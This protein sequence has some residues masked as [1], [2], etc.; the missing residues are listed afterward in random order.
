MPSK[1]KTPPPATIITTHI[2]AD[3]DAIASM[4]AAQ[5]L[6]P[7]AQVVFPGSAEKNIRNFFINSMVYLFN[8]ADIDEI[9]L[10]GVKRLVL[11]DTRRGQ[12]IGK[13]SGL[14]ENED[15]EI[16]IFDHHPPGEEDIRPDYEVY[17]PTGATVTILAN[18][19]KEKQIPISP[20]EATVMCLGIYEDTGSFTFS[21]TT[22][23]DFLA[24]AFLL[25]KGAN[26]NI[27]ADLTAREF[28]P[29]QVGLLSDLIKSA[30]HYK[31]NGIEVVVSAI[32]TE[33]YVPDFA[34]LV[35]KMQKMESL[36]ALFAVV[37]MGGKIHIV[38]RSRI[39]EVNVADILAPLE[40]GGHPFAAAATIRDKTL[41]Q[42]EALLFESLYHR[43]RPARHAS[44]LMSSPAITTQPDVSCKA[45]SRLMTRYNVNAL[46]VTEK[47]DGAEDIQGYISRQ[48]IEKA[49]YHKLGHVPVREYMSTELAVVDPTAEL[50]EIQEK[51]IER[52]QR[53]LPVVDQGVLKG[54]ITR[55]DLLTILVNQSQDNGNR[56]SDPLQQHLT[57]KTRNIRKLMR[58]RL[59]NR[60][61]DILIS[62]GRVAHDLGY[63][64]Y[65]IGGIVR[66]L[67]L[68]RQ[69]EDVDIVV[70]GDGIAL[71]KKYAKMAGARVH[72]YEKFGT[73]VIIYPDGFKIDVASARMEYYK[74]P[75]ALPT[76][77][78]SSL[79]LD[80]FRRDFTVNTLAVQLSPDSFGILLDFFSAQ[81]DIKEKTI[82][83]LH[84]LSFVE[85]PTRVFRAIRFEQ[86]FQFTIGK[87]TTG[88]IENAVKMDFF[89]RLSGRRVFSELRQILEE[90]SPAPAIN[91]LADFNLLAVIHPSITVSK[92]LIALISAVE[93]VLAWHDLLF[94]EESYNR[95]T[96]YFLALIKGCTLEISVDICRRLELAPRHLKF[97]SQERL[98]MENCILKLEHKLPATNSKIYNRLK[99]FKIEQILFMMAATRQEAVERALSH[100]VTQLRNT[101][102]LIGGKD[103]IEMGVPR[104]P[105]FREILDGVLEGKLDGK[106]QDRQDEFEFVRKR[107]KKT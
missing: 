107:L 16:H 27:I 41:A 60:I 101:Q 94:L 6:Y 75:A 21:S 36:N 38:A 47:K 2:N 64:A 46:L 59:P 22:E 99:E 32:S 96:V 70:E 86:R 89:K 40:G 68:Y 25:S 104:G 42:V 56:V 85:D 69:N 83:I 67:F 88:L 78:M 74:F 33:D 12:R 95:W 53:I 23:Q 17:Q 52:K 57:A 106:I 66:D 28:S 37:R 43:I 18:I 13:L 61:M 51:I 62:I 100:Y 19:L 92:P 63:N 1:K 76:V 14:L 55:T 49:L 84:N 8:M 105:M 97:F 54:V 44:D 90:E 77:E 98:V 58:E 65:I 48:V 87:L 11:V 73:A 93:K 26:L 45:A 82:R 50:P 81:R 35:H 9:D 34:F 20:E 29:E 72:T 3:F 30:T 103:L 80:L 10:A 102:I 31:I 39:A 91:R 7:D 24:A 4:L 71:A 15:M 5:K 79:K